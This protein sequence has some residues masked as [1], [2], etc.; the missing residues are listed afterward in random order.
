MD[1]DLVD[2]HRR[3]LVARHIQTMMEY[4]GMRH[5]PLQGIKDA[6]IGAACDALADISH[7]NK[8]HPDKAIGKIAIDQ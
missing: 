6:I 1:D 4:S 5:A 7:F 8:E 3:E 2:N